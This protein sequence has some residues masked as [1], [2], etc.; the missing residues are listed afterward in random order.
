MTTIQ[1][2]SAYRW[3]EIAVQVVTIEKSLG[4]NHLPVAALLPSIR[5]GSCLSPIRHREP[6]YRQTSPFRR[7]TRTHAQ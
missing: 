5:L 7:Q 3:R 4:E 2:S 6:D 1:E